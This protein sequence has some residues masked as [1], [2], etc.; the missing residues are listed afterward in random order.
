MTAAA[1]AALKAGICRD[2][3][4]ARHTICPHCGRCE[5]CGHDP[6]VDHHPE[7]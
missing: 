6:A 1:L 4:N 3:N 2:C 7:A 5:D